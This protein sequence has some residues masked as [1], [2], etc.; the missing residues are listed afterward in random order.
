MRKL[1]PV[2]G[3]KDLKKLSP[4][5]KSFN[6]TEDAY[7]AIIEAIEAVNTRVTNTDLAL[8]AYKDALAS[9]IDSHLGLFDSITVND[10][11]DIVNAVIDTLTATSAT[12]P[13]LN[14]NDLVTVDL[15]A[16]RA[17][18][19]EI[20]NVVSADITTVNST[21]VNATTGNFTKINADN[22]NITNYSIDNGAISNLTAGSADITTET[23][24]SSVINNAT[25]AT[26]GSTDATITNADINKATISDTYSERLY[27]VYFNHNKTFN[28]QVIDSSSISADGDCWCVLPKF[29]NGHFYLIAKN[30]TNGPFLWSLEIL[31]SLENVMFRWSNAEGEHQYLKDVELINDDNDKLQFIQIHFNT[32]NLATHIFFQCTDFNTT[33]PP[34]YYAVKQYDGIKNFKFTRLNGTYLPN[35]IFAGDFHA[36]TIEID[37]VE[38]E[39]VTINKHIMLPRGYDQY[40]APIGHTSGNPGDYVTP[41]IDEYN[42]EGIQWKEPVK[43]TVDGKLSDSDDLITEN[44]VSSYTGEK[45]GSITYTDAYTDGT[46]FY[47][48]DFTSEDEP[49]GTI[50][51]STEVG[52]YIDYD[53]KHYR[54]TQSED[55]PPVI[56]YWEVTSFGDGGTLVEDA[57]LIAALDA[58]TP[59]PYTKN[60]YRTGTASYN[61]KHLGDGTEVHGDA[62]IDRDLTVNRATE[63]NRHL[64][65]GSNTEYEAIEADNDKKLLDDALVIKDDGVDPESKIYRKRTFTIDGSIVTKL[66]E[67]MASNSD[68]VLE[69][70]LPIIYNQLRHA[71]ETSDKIDIEEGNFNKVITN[72]LYVNGTAHINNTEEHDVEG[73]YLTLRANNNSALANGTYSGIII[74]HYNSDGDL[75]MIVADNTGTARLG[76]GSGTRTTYPELY[77]DGNIY[78]TDP[79]DKAGTTVE[80]QGVLIEWQSYEKTDDYEHWTDAEWIVITFANTKPFL[81]REETADLNDKALLAWDATNER[82][83]D[84]PLPTNDEDVLTAHV[85]GNETTT[86]VFTDG[87][88]FYGADMI[89]T[90]EPSGTAGTP[91]TVG[92]FIYDDNVW[93]ACVGTTF[94]DSV[95]SFTDNTNWTEVTDPELI[96]ILEV[97]DPVT[98]SEVVY[99]EVSDPTISYQWKEKQAGSYVFASMAAYNTYIATHNIPNGSQ[100]IIENEVQNVFGDDING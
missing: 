52:L 42:N 75:L 18:I 99:T 85:V 1:Y 47:D 36:D 16:Q 38:F 89:A 80:P 79:E 93:F 91:T 62:T 98:I 45:E 63:L 57:T 69:D 77:Y 24:G 28:R 44:A 21:T 29:T 20:V 2:D 56:E 94:Y 67:L 54:K 17:A 84:I 15:T 74:N 9:E 37:S 48:I 72:T 5:S 86:T 6:L 23:V 61:I 14:S 30:G 7:N 68:K 27:N 76:T 26:L 73:D 40:G 41:V 34:S 33:T 53:N 31:N 13:T 60:T 78:F 66:D 43:A 22:A 95:D 82:A 4:T 59:I 8:Q 12:I 46:N 11:A 19:D 50:T 96:A 97:Q 55:N 70:G 10:R 88:N 49:E 32:N 92:Q 64:F 87:T 65:V 58:E 35:S 81:L 51:S 25:I 3:E 90:T 39:T 71:Y 83:Y 100:I